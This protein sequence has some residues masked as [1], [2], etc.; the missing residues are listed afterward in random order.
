MAQQGA[1]PREGFGGRTLLFLGL[2]TPLQPQTWLWLDAS[3]PIRRPGLPQCLVLLPV[4]HMCAPS[5]DCF[6][7]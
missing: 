7:P 5:Q 6:K 1:Q 4:L 2:L 3:R